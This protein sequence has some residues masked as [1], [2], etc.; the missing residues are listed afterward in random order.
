M[1]H[2]FRKKDLDQRISVNPFNWDIME[3]KLAIMETGEEIKGYK[4]IFRDDNG[5][6]LNVAK[7][8]YHPISNTDFGEIIAGFE[9]VGCRI[10]RSGEFSDG[11][12]TYVQ[13]G[14]TL[15]PNFEVQ[16]DDLVRSMITVVNSHNGAVALRTML[17]TIRIVCSNTFSLV[18]K[19]G[20]NMFDNIRHTKSAPIRL[21]ALR[22]GI[23]DM[24]MSVREVERVFKQFHES[25]IEDIRASR[26]LK[27]VF[28]MKNTLPE[29]DRWGDETDEFYGLTTKG[30]NML[31][32][33][34]FE[35]EDS[36]AYGTAW[37]VF[38]AVTAYASKYP[39]DLVGHGHAVRQ[40][41]YNIL[42]QHS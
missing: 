39:S 13:M 1:K 5:I 4:G 10:E 3:R 12:I 25:K 30:E 29:G 2:I 40:R 41:A 35:Y 36:G 22:L 38:N 37:G 20:K 18:L 8:S 32:D 9:K 27:N 21:E 34:K 42:Q 16:K 15:L 31:H 7:D 28:N 24:A 33:L 6:I 23:D 17:T 26:I 14:N 19:Q 11:K